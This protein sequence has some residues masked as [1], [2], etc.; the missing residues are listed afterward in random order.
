MREH[1]AFAGM[2][3][4]IV[5]HSSPNQREAEGRRAAGLALVLGLAALALSACG[6]AS[7]DVTE[8]RGLGEGRIRAV[9]TTGMIADI[10]RNVGGKRV[11]V[12]QMMGAGIDPHLY[13]ATESD[14]T[15]L[16]QADI[17]FYN[18]L[19]LE[20]RMGEIFEQMGDSRPTVA[21]GE[22]VPPNERLA[23]P[24][25]EGQPDP[26]VWM[27]VR[28]WMK[29]TEAVRDALIALDGDGEALYRA[30][31]DAYLAELEA[32]D[33]SVEEQIARIPEEQCVLVTA[34]DA[35]QYFGQRYGIEVFAPQGISTQSEA[36]VE[37][38]RQTIE[39][40]VSRHIPAIFVESSVPPDVI[41]AIVAG[42]RAEGHAVSIG[43]QLYSDAMGELGTPEGTYVGMIRRNTKTIVSALAGD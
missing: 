32:L 28:H 39:L 43:G 37:D 35:F 30:N 5:A 34:H 41:E 11:E 8:A 1:T 42:V 22:A 9:A 6:S 33:A 26:H 25:Y 40:V 31:A 12:V 15:T 24:R 38:I 23:D 36:G 29:A 17:I 13:T 2:G 27:N 20:A 16:T 21:V 7:T 19:N 10:V 18:G 4:E 14:V 3:V